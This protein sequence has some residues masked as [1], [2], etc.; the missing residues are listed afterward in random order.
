VYAAVMFAVAVAALLVSIRPIL[1]AGN[2][3]PS[4]VMRAE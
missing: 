3:S 4:V 1:R 2:V